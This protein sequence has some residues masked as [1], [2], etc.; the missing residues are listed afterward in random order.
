[1]MTFRQ[2]APLPTKP[3]NGR[4]NMIAPELVEILACPACKGPVEVDEARQ[5]LVCRSCKLA[6]PLHAHGGVMLPVLLVEE[7]RPLDLRSEN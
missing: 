6:F 7:A 1:M 4:E 3:P 5:A 2:D